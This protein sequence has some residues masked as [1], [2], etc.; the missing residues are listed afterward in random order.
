MRLPNKDKKVSNGRRLFYSDTT[1]FLLP[2][3]LFNVVPICFSVAKGSSAT[4]KTDVLSSMAVAF[5][6]QCYVGHFST[7]AMAM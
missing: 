7:S 5:H 4:V 6:S 1:G 3:Q 2:V